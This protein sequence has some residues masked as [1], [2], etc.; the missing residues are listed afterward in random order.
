[1]GA[2]VR[3]ASESVGIALIGAGWISGVYT[4]ALARV[5]GTWVV[6]VASRTRASAEKLAE[7]CGAPLA[8]D[9][10]ELERVLGDPRV[11]VVCVNST[12]HLHAEH[13]IAALRAGKDV[14]VEKPLCLS[15]EEADRMIEAARA[16]GQGL[17]YAE[18]LCFAPHYRHAR[19]LVASG[20]LGRVLF[21]R[22][23]EKHDGPYSDW[24]YQLEEA[25]GGALL[26]MGCH[27]IE[28]LRWLLGKP[29][30]ARVS[31][32]L[33]TLRHQERTRLDDT[34]ILQ[35]EL[36]DGT[37]LVSESSWS[38]QGGMESTLEVHG[39]EGTLHVDLLGEG[40]VRV[41]RSDEGWKVEHPD[42]LGLSGYPQEL[43]HFLDAFAR[44]VEPEETA[45]DGRV[46]LEI[47]LAGYH[48]AR[49][50]RPVELPFDPGP[51][52]RPIDLWL[53]R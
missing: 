6:G 47:M 20:K 34:A 40:G 3:R 46:V 13:T 16:A 51:V 9:Y 21:A 37:R 41:W 38:L 42:F 18:N 32:D 45:H 8:V 44:G 14:I 19:D 1:V 43:E 26:D 39:T 29:P 10:G 53:R 22:Q 52:R 33:A 30:V 31:G 4:Q 23:S 50:G 7:S 28:C 35:L 49:E 11:S 36:A 2:A 24:F 27:S 5:A 15:F 17:A 12:N 48:S 25:G